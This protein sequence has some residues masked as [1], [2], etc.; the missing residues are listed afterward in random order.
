M[1]I[2]AKVF[3]DNRG[4]SFDL[5]DMS[6][7]LVIGEDTLPECIYSHTKFYA[8]EQTAD[9]HASATVDKFRKATESERRKMCGYDT[10]TECR[11]D[12]AGRTK[13]VGNRNTPVKQPVESA[14][15]PAQI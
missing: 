12:W 11:V 13:R 9:R 2:E 15:C 4:F 7:I 6:D 3:G 1:K 5:L 10:A 14:D 8:N